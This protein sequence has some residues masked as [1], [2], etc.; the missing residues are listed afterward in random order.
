MWEF[1]KKISADTGKEYYIARCLP[2]GL[3]AYADTQE[4]AIYKLWLMFSTSLNLA[5]E[6]LEKEVMSQQTG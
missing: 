6:D 4:E 1:G 2:L 5:Y 3:T